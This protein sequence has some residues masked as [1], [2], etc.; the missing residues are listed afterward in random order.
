M[1]DLRAEVARKSDP[2]HSKLIQTGR[3]CNLGFKATM[4]I[5]IMIEEAVTARK[6]PICGRVMHK[7]SVC[8]HVASV[9]LCVH[10]VA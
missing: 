4:S 9:V 6:V 7:C 3:N 5:T 1:K 2:K 8:C 10:G